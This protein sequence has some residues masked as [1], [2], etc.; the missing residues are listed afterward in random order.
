MNIVG[1]HSVQA[2]RLI[3]AFR[4]DPDVEISLQCIDPVLPAVVR[5]TRGVRT[6]ANAAVYYSQLIPAIL[7]SDV[8]HAFTS[9]FWGYTLWVMPAVRLARLL[10]KKIVVNY[11][12]GRASQHLSASP[13]AVASLRSADALAVP[14]QYL[15]DVFTTFGLTPEVIPNTIDTGS[16]PFRERRQLRPEFLT[17]RGFEAL[18]NV[19][20][21]LK[22]FRIV[23]DNYPDAHFTVA[24]DGPLRPA[25]QALAADMR[26][27]ATFTG[28]VSQARM[29]ALY[30]AAD[31]YVMSPN[32]DN[33]PLTILECFACGLPVV[34]TDAGGVP[35]LAHHEQTALLAPINSHEQLAGQCVRLLQDPE[36]AQR[37]TRQARQECIARYSIEP[38]RDAWR[39]L[40]KRLANS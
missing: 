37:I 30:D 5:R 12:D 29:A 8:I 36:L 4:D 11:H 32:I 39:H 23:Q 16:Y 7:R 14:S 18:Y 6:V 20:C 28:A 21:T 3:R 19:E 35:Y 25:L 17:N 26:L 40:Y 38:V 22:A 2:D 9:S 10:S 33:M 13:S 34:S 1:G 15:R 24:N 31:I 27:N